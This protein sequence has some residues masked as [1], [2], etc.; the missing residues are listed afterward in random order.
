MFKRSGQLVFSPS[1]LIT[2]LESPFASWM[3]RLHAEDRSACPA[4]DARDASADLLSK[5][6]TEHELAVLQRFKDAGHTVFEV[7]KE[8]CEATERAMRDGHA[9]IYQASLRLGAFAGYADFLL[10]VEKP[11]SL[12]AFSYEV[13]DSKLARRAKPYFVLQLCAYAAMLEAIQGKRPETLVIITGDHERVALRTEDFFY[14]FKTL[15]RA[16]LEEQAKFDRERRPMPDARAEHR[17]WTTLAEQIL[18]ER[19]HLSRVASI[20]SNQI[21]R[22]ESAGISTMKALATSRARRVAKLD[23]TVFDRLKRQARLQIDSAKLPQPL[24]EIIPPNDD[25]P[26]RG[27]AL[28]PPPSRGD[29]FFDMEGYPFDGIEYLFGAVT[30]EG[31]KRVFHDFWA[32][33]EAEEKRAFEGLVDFLWSRFRAD[34]SMH[35]YHYA[36]YEV[37]ALRRLMGQHGTREREIDALLRANVFVDLYQVVRQG[38]VVGEPRY[39]L[40]NVEHLYRPKREGGVASAGESV[41]EYARWLEERDGSDWRTSAILRGIRD[42]NEEDCVSTYELREWLHAR[43]KEAGIGYVPP[44]KEESEGDDAVDDIAAGE[45][46]PDEGSVAR[47]LHDVFDFHAR[48]QKPIWWQIFDWQGK[49]HDELVDAFDCLG[50]LRRTKTPRI[51]EKR[52]WL[53]EYEVPDQETK[54]DEGNAVFFSVDLARGELHALDLEARRASVKIGPKGEVPPD[55]VSLLPA[56]IVKPEPIN[57]ALQGIV[58]AFRRA[59]ALSGALETLLHRKPPRVR[60]HQGGALLRAGVDRLDEVKRVLAGMNETT[61]AFQGPPGSG[62]TTTAAKAIVHLIELGHRV[63]VTSNGHKAI[64]KLMLDVRRVAGRAKVRALKVGRVDDPELDMVESGKDVPYDGPDAP[65]L[66]GGTAWAMC[67]ERAIGRFDYLFV[68]E[69]SQVSLA[70][71]IAMSRATK[72]LVLLGDQMQLGQVLLGSHPG[73]SGASALGYL[74]GDARTIPPELGVFLDTSWRMHPAVCRVVSE[75]VYEGRL[76]ADPACAARVVKVPKSAKHVREEAG[77][78]FVPVEHEG[79]AQAS[80]EEVERIAEIVDELLGRTLVEKPEKGRAGA[81]RKV[82]ESDILIVAPYNMQVRAIARRLGPKIRVASVDKFQGQEAPIA[83]VSMCAS[84]GDE[85][86]RGME[87]LFNV[88]RLNVALSRAQAL[89]IVVGSPRLAT[90]RVGSVEQMRLLNFWCRVAGG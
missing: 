26:R 74:L 48:E 40:K 25:E 14:Y 86:P 57:L 35:V 6:G 34:P 55:V 3:D 88:N 11:S 4:P 50:K 44:T 53:Y 79:N 51:A 28:L 29:V 47:L 82:R 39:S 85:V 16:F 70:N 33:D 1:D 37:T 63:G 23:D 81:T 17:R 69:A 89:A 20:T 13:A 52:S 78:V 66:V 27:L 62:K 68:D 22:L 24:F 45:A 73:K 58:D 8:D 80:D 38:L 32:H 7:P 2:Y 9:V 31:R 43:Q 59:G 18:E 87:F 41:T 54:L 49:T 67:H 60:G 77:V 61:I 76:Q 19:D 90:T 30:L 36:P 84:S 15:E 65:N 10:R 56:K 75:A 64:E 42:Y 72:N 46:R 83:I 21:A 5:K 12:G 71:V